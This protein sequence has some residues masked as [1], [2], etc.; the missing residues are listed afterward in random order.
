MNAGDRDLVDELQGLIAPAAGELVDQ[1]DA[2]G[3]G[4]AAT[5]WVP[6]P[7]RCGARWSRRHRS[8]L[9]CVDPLTSC[10]LA[11]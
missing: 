2:A 6:T 10:Q 11:R 5:A 9:S 7:A 8:P 3:F 4:A 1:P